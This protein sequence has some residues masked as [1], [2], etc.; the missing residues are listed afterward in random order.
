MS[1]Q[2]KHPEPAQKYFAMAFRAPEGK[3]EVLEKKAVVNFID[4]ESNKEYQAVLEDMLWYP[5]YF[6]SDFI[7]KLLL[8][9]TASEVRDEMIRRYKLYPGEEIAIIQF[10]KL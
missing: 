4:P 5:E 1:K 3:S 6:I 10:R 8:Q 9:K 2:I 7:C